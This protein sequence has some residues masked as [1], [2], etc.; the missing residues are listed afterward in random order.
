MQGSGENS[1]ARQLGQQLIQQVLECAQFPFADSDASVC[2]MPLKFFYDLALALGDSDPQGYDLQDQGSSERLSASGR[3][4]FV[5][6]YSPIFLS[7]LDI[8]VVQIMIP[9][10]T[11]LRND[12]ISDEVVE[13]RSYWKDAVLDCCGVLGFDVCMSRLCGKLQEAVSL[14]DGQQMRYSIVESILFAIQLISPWLPRDDDRYTPALIEFLGRLSAV[15]QLTYVQLTVIELYG[16]LAFWFNDHPQFL[17]PVMTKLFGDLSNVK[18]SAAASR[19]L[20]QILRQCRSVPGLPVTDL[21]GHIHKLR[22]SP[23]SAALSMEAELYLLEG[24]AVVISSSDSNN[25]QLSAAASAEAFRS[26]VTPILLEL[27]EAV[28][29]LTAHPSALQTSSLIANIDRLTVLFRFFRCS[30]SSCLVDLLVNLIPLFKQANAVLSSDRVAEHICRCY[31]HSIRNVGVNFLPYLPAFCQHLADE[32]ALVPVA[33]YLYAGLL[34]TTEPF[35]LLNCVLFFSE[36]NYR[37]V[38]CASFEGEGGRGRCI[39]LPI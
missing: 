13:M 26:I 24:I 11:I 25:Q 10:A 35:K 34:G 19:T 36:R 9:E 20:M 4:A 1:A 12:K 3:N 5:A 38:C 23:S 28:P 16:L 18:V 17:G 22:Q 2:K 29:Q 27:R 33:A 37:R 32:F 8:I 31:K 6:L 15:D 21:Y 30:D 7:L 14:T 39:A